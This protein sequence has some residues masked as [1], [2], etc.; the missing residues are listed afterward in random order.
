MEVLV[1]VA[2]IAL[3]IAILL[4]ALSKARTNARRAACLAQLREIGHGIGI[5]INVSNDLLPDPYILGLHPFRMAPGRRTPNDPY[6][7]PEKYGLAVALAKVRALPGDSPVWVC[8]DSVRWMQ[9]GGNSYLFAMDK[10]SFYWH[11]D[12]KQRKFWNRKYAN[13]MAG[14]KSQAART[15]IV[16]DNY[17]HKYGLTG[18]FGPFKTG[19]TIPTNERVFP[20]AQWNVWRSTSFRVNALFLD[21]HAAQRVD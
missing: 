19:Y 11:E 12:P 14:K 6:A 5:Y 16:L 1:V 8:P 21:F 2:I 20:H 7:L 3:L 18:F 15:E 13:V 17:T 9:E 4:P 10:L